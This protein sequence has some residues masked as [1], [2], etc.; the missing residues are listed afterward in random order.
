MCGI[1]G[2]INITGRDPVSSEMVEEMVSVMNYRG[3]DAKGVYADDVLGTIGHARLSVIDRSAVSDQPF[4]LPGHDVFISFNGEIYNYIEL[5]RELEQSGYQFRTA[6]DTE[7]LLAAYHHWGD[8]CVEHFNGMWAFTILDK[9]RNRVFCSRDRFGIKPFLFAR[10]NGKLFFASEAKAIN[11]VSGGAQPDFGALAS[12][13]KTSFGGQNLQTCFA[14]VRRLQPAHN[15]VV[16]NGRMEIQRYWD[17]PEVNSGPTLKYEEAVEELERLLRDSIKLRLRSDVP[18]GFT[19]SGGIDSAGVV[20]LAGAGEGEFHAYTASYQHEKYRA[21]ETQEAIQVAKSVGLKHHLVSIDWQDV[22]PTLKKVVYHLESPHASRAMLPYYKIMEVAKRDVTVVLEG[23][24]A[25]ELC[26][27][28]VERLVAPALLD[29]ARQIQPM[30]GFNLMR[31]GVMGRFGMSGANFIGTT[32]KTAIPF[33]HKLYRMY[34]GDERM[35]EGGLATAPLRQDL[36][37]DGHPKQRDYVNTHLCEHHRSGLVNLLQYSDALP[38]AHS[39]ESRLP[40]MD[41]R[42]VEFVFGLPGSFKLKGGYGKSILRDSLRGSVPERILNAR[43]KRGFDTPTSHW[44]REHMDEIVNPVLLSPECK[45]RGLF[46]MKRL[47]KMLVNHQQGTSNLGNSIYK[48][49][50]T[51]LWF[52]TFID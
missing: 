46:D 19:L 31:H 48:W 41:Y 43:L 14:G 44:F 26:G 20:S 18:V 24:G 17:Y 6:S 1:A 8:S 7:V 5:R 28:Y 30:A 35:Y 4:Q 23:Q 38:M 22:L 2:I 25:D 3:P 21:D 27:G 15:L 29:C 32:I 51:E 36:G 47:E 45:K 49:L 9:E 10:K 11:L 12:V 52:Q 42:L 37:S 40:F 39:I 50:I 34:R 33:S 16:E 13:I